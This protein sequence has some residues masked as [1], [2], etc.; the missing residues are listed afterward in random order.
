MRHYSLLVRA[1]LPE[2]LPH[3]YIILFRPPPPASTQWSWASPHLGR[4]YWQPDQPPPAAM[5]GILAAAG[6]QGRIIHK[7]IHTDPRARKWSKR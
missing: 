6:L 2:L 7:H 3:T 5:I 4:R 1:M